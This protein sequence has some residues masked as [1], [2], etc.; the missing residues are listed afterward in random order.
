MHHKIILITG[1]GSGIGKAAAVALARRGHTVIATTHHSEDARALTKFAQA[2]KI[3]LTSFALDITQAAHRKK[4]LAYD[5]DVLINNA[6]IGE[7]GSLAEIKM[8]RVRNNFEVNVFSTFELAQIALGPMLKKDSG[9]LI[10]VSSV[11]GRVTAPFFGPYSMSKFA[12]SSG[13]QM[14]R[15]ELKQITH[16]VH[17]ALIEPGAYH[18]GFNQKMVQKKYEWMDKKSYFFKILGKIKAA[19][20]QQF[21]VVEQKNL[22]TIVAKI[23]QAAEAD[24]PKLRYSAPWWQAYGVAFLRLVS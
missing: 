15:K 17:V 18:T 11:L 4:I 14:L 22:S 1:S 24:V 9:T 13:A 2:Q 16:S 20:A 8:E 19:E 5:L 10:F 7:T 6:G 23:V 3:P 21:R 12:L